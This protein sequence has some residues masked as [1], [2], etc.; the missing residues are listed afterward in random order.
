MPLDPLELT[1]H[2]LLRI[3]GVE[4][5]APDAPQL[6]A[7]APQTVLRAPWVVIRRAP[8][9][10][11]LIPVGLRGELRSQRFATWLPAAAIVE[12]VTSRQL[13]ASGA[14]KNSPRRTHVPA[15]QAL[16]RVE[17]IMRAH[18]F[19]YQ[20]GPTG[21]V[22]FELASGCPTATE[23]SDL[24]LAVYLDRPWSVASARSL[25]SALATLPVRTDLL[26]E[27]PHGAVALSEYATM[28]GSFV[29]RT[30]LGPR[31]VGDLW[32]DGERIAAA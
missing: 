31:L 25:Q 16:D 9:C 23:R 4:A 21:S 6:P 24:D 1:P 27:M 11:S 3:I 10:D 2:T 12:Y 7:W 18:G 13:S 5:L 17:T 20:W 15:L 26:V 32:S 30:A 22:G 28:Q 19:E 8:V 29:L 14:W